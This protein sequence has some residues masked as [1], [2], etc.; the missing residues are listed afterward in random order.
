MN[1]VAVNVI[2]RYLCGTVN[3]ILWSIYSFGC[4]VFS[5]LRTFCTYFHSGNND[6]HF[7][8]Q[9]IRVSFP[10]FSLLLLLSFLHFSFFLNT[11]MYC[12]LSIFPSYYAPPPN[13]LLD[14]GHSDWGEMD[15]HVLMT[16]DIKQFF[17]IFS[18]HLCFSSET[19]LFITGSSY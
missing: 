15:F 1:S 11:S 18:G 10:V 6:L 16:K 9:C 5:S 7:C 13:D 4:S 2:L 19:I 8:Q 17:L 14:V 3:Y 12:M